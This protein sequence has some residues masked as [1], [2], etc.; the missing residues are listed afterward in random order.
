MG[1]E[2]VTS[3]K[4]GPD[5]AHADALRRMLL[6]PVWGASYEKA[7]DSGLGALRAKAA[8]FAAALAAREPGLDASV[9][10]VRA[11]LVSLAPEMHPDSP[12]VDEALAARDAWDSAWAGEL[13]A[14]AIREMADALPEDADPPILDAESAEVY[15]A[16]ND[17]DRERYRRAVAAW[18]EAAR[19]ARPAPE[20]GMPAE[21]PRWDEDR[22]QDEIARALVYVDAR[23]AHG[24][25][26]DADEEWREVHAATDARDEAR[27][28]GLRS[29]P[30]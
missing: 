13:M 6:D 12:A 28:S 20:D 5:P 11:L 8:R 23:A 29:R 1:G 7:C 16:A 22:A 2:T 4:N 24:A 9:D 26:P 21:D 25:A 30:P 18:A 10:A 17:E 15:A 14:L 3:S 19:T 27:D